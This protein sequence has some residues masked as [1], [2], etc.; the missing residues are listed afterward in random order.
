MPR[1]ARLLL[2][3]V[4]L[5]LIQRGNNR[6]ACFY[7]EEDYLFYLDNLKLQAEQ[8]GCAVHAWCL[9]TNHVHLLVTPSKPESASLMMKGL[10]QRFVQY[11]NRTYDRSGTLWEGRFRSCLLQEEDYVL[12]C[13]RY[14]EMKPCTRRHGR[15]SRRVS[16]VQLRR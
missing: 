3:G 7:S 4:P 1:R 9:M 14:I 15:A 11:I 6:S 5:H 12:A 13:Y 16:L 10:G 8:H 2:P